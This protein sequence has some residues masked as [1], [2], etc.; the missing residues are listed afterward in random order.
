MPTWYDRGGGSRDLLGVVALLLGFSRRF[1]D[2]RGF[3]PPLSPATPTGALSHRYYQPQ[4]EGEAQT[5]GLMPVGEHYQ[6]DAC[7]VAN[8]KAA[9]QIRRRRLTI[10]EALCRQQQQQQQQLGQQQAIHGH[11]QQQKPQAP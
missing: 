9:S 11:Q 10:F 1:V 6:V 7:L 2:R 5:D 4:L 8:L 3:S